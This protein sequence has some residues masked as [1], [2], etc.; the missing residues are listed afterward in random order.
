[1]GKLNRR[2]RARCGASL[3]ALVLVAGCGSRSGRPPTTIDAA[4]AASA[5]RALSHVKHAA[6]E[7]NAASSACPAGSGYA[8]CETQAYQ[9]TGIANAISNY[10]I[11]LRQTE[12]QV[13]GTCRTKLDAVRTTVQAYAKLLDQV[14][15]DMVTLNLAN[16]HAD[17]KEITTQNLALKSTHQ[18]AHA[19]CH[20]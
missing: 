16:L 20:D 18:A 14:E 11:V 12:N 5:N 13:G 6:A 4:Q 15:H 19:A 1:M 3:L 2:R 7:W 10:A 8:S 9:T 17:I